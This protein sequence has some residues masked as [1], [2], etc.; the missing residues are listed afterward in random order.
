MS[1]LK[2]L[3]NKI[4]DKPAVDFTLETLSSGKVNMTAF[5]EGKNSIIFFWAT[6]CPHCR[7]ALAELSA[8]KA[9][10]E[11]KGIKV[12]LVDMGE[13]KEV[14]QEYAAR[15]KVNYEI[16]LDVDSSLSDSYSIV[17]VPTFIFV[18]QAGI[19]RAIEHGLSE[20]Y[21]NLFTQ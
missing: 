5:R 21:E 6:W 12:I 7:E 11:Q 10:I 16:F 13:E 18:N 8:Q 20:G 15:N 2:F 19:V 1:F 17:G 14:V 4:V 9:E 3:Q